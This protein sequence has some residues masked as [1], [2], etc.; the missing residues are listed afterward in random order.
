[1]YYFHTI[2]VEI[3][4][5]FFSFISF[6]LFYNYREHFNRCINNYLL[7]HFPFS[8]EHLRPNP[9][10]V[11]NV[12][13]HIPTVHRLQ[14]RLIHSNMLKFLQSVKKKKFENENME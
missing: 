4:H 8:L 10:H 9:M 11:R 7:T 12:D 6:L 14:H 5:I 13:K 1:M 2:V 3:L